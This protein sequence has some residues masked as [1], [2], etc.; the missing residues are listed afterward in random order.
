M[1]AWDGISSL[2]SIYL[3]NSQLQCSCSTLGICSVASLSMTP[4]LWFES[5]QHLCQLCG[6]Q[7]TSSSWE[8]IRLYLRVHTTP[9]GGQETRKKQ[10]A[11][12]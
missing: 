1:G 6:S 7:E 11:W 8:E 12:G 9:G 4:R 5:S 10:R 2:L 3:P